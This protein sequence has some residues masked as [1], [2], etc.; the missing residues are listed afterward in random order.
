[1]DVLRRSMV[2][3]IA[4]LSRSGRPSIVPLYFVHHDGRIGLGTPVWT[5]TARNVA[6][7]PRVSVLFE[8][9]RDPGDRRVLRIGGRARVR[10]DR[11]AVRAYAL[12]AARKYVLTPGG[13]RNALAHVRQ[14]PL[15]RR[16][17]AQS[18]E[19]GPTCV[20]E[21]TPGRAEFVDGG[22]PAS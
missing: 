21:V 3:R 20:I 6:A 14:L 13:I 19:R 7:D 18:A 15:R 9:E 22:T 4:T 16:Y 17:A 2:A 10:G 8:V 1:M 5:L 11:E 12:R